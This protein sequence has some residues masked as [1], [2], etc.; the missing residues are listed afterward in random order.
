MTDINPGSIFAWV[1]AARPATLTAAFAP[2]AVGTACAW[3]ADGLRWDAAVAALLAW[4]LFHE[5][6]APQQAVGGVVMLVGIVLARKGS[7]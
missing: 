1:L 7:R 5:S 4:W 6:P 3:R 2:V